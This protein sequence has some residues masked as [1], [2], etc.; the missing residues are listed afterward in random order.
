MKDL[1]FPLAVAMAFLVG[2]LT[3][4]GRPVYDVRDFGAAGRVADRSV[5]RAHRSK[6]FEKI[7]FRNVDLPC[8]FEALNADVR[9]EGGTLRRI[10]LTEDEIVRR[11]ADMEAGRNLLY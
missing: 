1:G 2:C 11:T 9:I 6:P 5:I 10:A 8:G 3:T 7:V 4:G